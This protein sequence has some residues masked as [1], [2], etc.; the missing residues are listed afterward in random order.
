[1]KCD[2]L[3]T[4]LVLYLHCITPIGEKGQYWSQFISSQNYDILYML[5]IN[6]GSIGSPYGVM[7]VF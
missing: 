2:F 1:M 3:K 7:K 4:L 6:T 5:N